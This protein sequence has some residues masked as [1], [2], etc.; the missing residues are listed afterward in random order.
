[1]GKTKGA[2][3]QSTAPTRPTSTEWKAEELRMTEAECTVAASKMETMSDEGNVSNGNKNNLPK[4][5]C[6]TYVIIVFAIC[7]G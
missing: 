3:A 5:V 1:M 6:I 7:K 4:H 2:G